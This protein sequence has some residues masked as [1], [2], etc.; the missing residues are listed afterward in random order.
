MG[1][2][3]RKPTLV[4]LLVLIA[5]IGVVV[6]LLL[7]V[8]QWAS[9]GSIRFPVRV[10]VFD[11]VHGKPIANAR[12]GIFGAA[13]LTDFKSLEEGND[14]Y[15]PKVRVRDEN[16]GTTDADGAVVIDYEFTTGANYQRPTPN[17]HLRRAWVHVEAEGYGGIVVPVR[18]ESQPVATL[19]TRKDL[20]VSVGLIPVE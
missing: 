17:A 10:L 12:V 6:A 8:P 3:L 16:R 7:P 5:G 14:E 2:Q 15:D 19:R 20:V 4:E 11:A 18:Y 1:W 9:S 13:P